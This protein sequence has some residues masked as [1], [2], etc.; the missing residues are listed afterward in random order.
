MRRPQCRSERSQS[1]RGLVGD[2]VFGRDRR[3]H[4][5]RQA[6]GIPIGR[7]ARQG[8]APKAEALIRHEVRSS[9]TWKVDDGAAVLPGVDLLEKDPVAEF[10]ATQGLVSA[11][12]GRVSALAARVGS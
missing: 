7:L 2:E 4:E 5:E 11:S 10:V 3:I 1:D 9:E 6:D 12:S 8:P